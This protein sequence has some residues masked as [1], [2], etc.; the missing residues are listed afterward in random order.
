MKKRETVLTTE[1]MQVQCSG[2]T[3]MQ[4]HISVSL[5]CHV[6]S[7][8]PQGQTDS[9]PLPP[10]E[11]PGMTP[12]ADD[13]DNLVSDEVFNQPLT[14]KVNK[15]TLGAARGQRLKAQPAKVVPDYVESSDES[16][17]ES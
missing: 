1:N 3:N 16:D 7:P 9:E 6:M 14:S 15:T 11:G 10:Q 12:D 5:S 13:T 2:I 8:R 4:V 17:G